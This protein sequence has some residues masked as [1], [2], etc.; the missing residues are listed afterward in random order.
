M[1]L[2]VL[3]LVLAVVSHIYIK[4]HPESVE[5]SGFE[6]QELLQDIQLQTDEKIQHNIDDEHSDGSTLI[7]NGWAFIENHSTEFTNVVI[8]L[9][10]KAGNER[11]FQTEKVARTDVSA[12]FG[13]SLYEG[14]GFSAT[15]EMK[16]FDVDEYKAILYVIDSKKETYYRLELPGEI[17]F[18]GSK[19]L[20]N[21]AG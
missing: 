17:K 3:F 6:L 4:T 12:A 15:C 19:V 21:A 18:D 10:N 2:S 9:R 1:A 13:N 16:G 7:L 14:S 8:G 5:P 11:V 20:Y